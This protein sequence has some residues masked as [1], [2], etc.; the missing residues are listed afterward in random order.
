MVGQV[1]HPIET[2]LV[3]W[4]STVVEGNGNV[5]TY[6]LR[7][8]FWGMRLGSSYLKVFDGIATKNLGIHLGLYITLGRMWHDG[9]RDKQPD[10]HAKQ[11]GPSN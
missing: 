1:E 9:P 5:W 4:L 8:G 10:T 6:S 11:C 2:K 3:H 7:I